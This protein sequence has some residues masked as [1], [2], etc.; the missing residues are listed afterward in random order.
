MTTK[1]FILS[2]ILTLTF[3]S[4][5]S[6]LSCHN[7][8][9]DHMTDEMYNFK[10]FLAEDQTSE[11][12]YTPYY[13]CSHFTRD[14]RDNAS[15]QN[16]IMYGLLLST[17]PSFQGD[18]HAACLVVINNAPYVVESIYDEVY[19]FEDYY[20]KFGNDYIIIYTHGNVPA[21]FSGY[22]YPDIDMNEYNTC[23]I[24]RYL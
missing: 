5:V 7:M 12:E 17:H 1:I 14:L 4:S 16:I 13:Q 21:R 11:R 6:G 19:T 20:Y 23:D 8:T 9:E 18:G 15:K 3:I 24:F 22:K 2:I 10:V